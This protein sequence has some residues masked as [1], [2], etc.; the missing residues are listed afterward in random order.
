MKQSG[1][2]FD[3]ESLVKGT[4]DAGVRIFT[5]TVHISK[6]GYLSFYCIN[7]EGKYHQFRMAK[8]KNKVGIELLEKA[9]HNSYALKKS[10]TMFAGKISCLSDYL[11]L[12]FFLGTDFYSGNFPLYQEKENVWWFD[13]TEAHSKR[14]PMKKK[15]KHPIKALRG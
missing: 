1:V 8:S 13:L 10:K 11:D 14:K 2:I 3:F 9:T 15:S 5:P 12:D 7:D 6:S 4:S